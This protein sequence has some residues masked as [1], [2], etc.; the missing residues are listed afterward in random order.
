[1]PCERAY[2][3]Y[4]LARD[5]VGH[6][7]PVRTDPQSG[8]TIPDAT[9]TVRFGDFNGD[10]TVTLAD[11]AQFFSCLTDPDAGVPTGCEAKDFD[12]DG[13]VDLFDFA[14]FQIEFGG[15]Q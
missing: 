10:H 15:S 2:R 6:V 7:E 9:T 14:G 11:Y 1:M 12:L 5:H 4:G 3:F 8:A 13:D